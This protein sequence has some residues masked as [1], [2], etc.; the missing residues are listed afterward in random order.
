MAKLFQIKLDNDKIDRIKETKR[1]YSAIKIQWF[2]LEF[3]A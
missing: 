2:D 1:K 3:K